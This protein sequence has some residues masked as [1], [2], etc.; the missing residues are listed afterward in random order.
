MGLRF[1]A[2]SQQAECL[3]IHTHASCNWWS[4]YHHY[5][6]Y[7]QWVSLLFFFRV[8]AAPPSNS[9]VR[10]P[11]FQGITVVL[12][13]LFFFFFASVFVQGAS[14]QHLSRCGLSLHHSH[15]VLV[16]KTHEGE[17]GETCTAS[18]AQRMHQFI[19]F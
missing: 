3:V 19:L 15:I 11:Y 9:A 8:H 5:Y 17:F 14:P 16:N 12:V 6:H 13:Q 1:D 10:V 7:L 18:G 4:L 2:A